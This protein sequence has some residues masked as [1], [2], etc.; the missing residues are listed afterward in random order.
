MAKNKGLNFEEIAKHFEENPPDFSP[1][2]C[3]RRAAEVVR[4]CCN[5]LPRINL[6]TGQ[7]LEGEQLSAEELCRR[8]YSPPA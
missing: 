5:Q 3:E 6:E 1:D 8:G 2:E 4:R 7:P